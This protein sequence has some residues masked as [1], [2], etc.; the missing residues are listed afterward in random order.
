MTST[1]AGMVQIGAAQYGFPVKSASEWYRDQLTKENTMNDFDRHLTAQATQARGEAEQ[2]VERFNEGQNVYNPW[3][4]YAEVEPDGPDPADFCINVYDGEH[5]HIRLEH[6]TGFN[7]LEL[8][9]KWAETR[10]SQDIAA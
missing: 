3:G 8:F 5:G 10:E 1:L 6:F 7:P 4:D 9:I 2:Y